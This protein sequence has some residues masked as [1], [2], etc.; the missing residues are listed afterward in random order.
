M[1]RAKMEKQNVVILKLVSTVAVNVVTQSALE[2]QLAHIVIP[3]FASVRKRCK[4]VQI[5][6]LV[7]LLVKME[8]V[9]VNVERL[10]ILAREMK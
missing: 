1:T 4:L 9:L 7:T 10:R 2:N 6:K 3:V 5:L 8:L